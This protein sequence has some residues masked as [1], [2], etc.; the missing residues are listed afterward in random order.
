MTSTITI[1]TRNGKA[2]EITFRRNDTEIVS[3]FIVPAGIVH[4]F[5]ID[6]TQ[7]VTMRTA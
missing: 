2:V 7:D 5:T 4:T 1:D 3:I 6:E